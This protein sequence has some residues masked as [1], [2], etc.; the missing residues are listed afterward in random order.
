MP[1][2]AKF[3]KDILSNKRKLE[4]HETVCLNEECSVILLK[5]LPPILNDPGS[6]TISCTIG[7]NYFEHSL[8]DLGASV[9]LMPLSIYR[10]LGLGE[11]KPTTISL[12]LANRSIKRPK[13]IIEDEIVK[14]DKFIFPADFII[15]EME[16]DSNIPLI[17]GRPFLATGRALIDVYDRKMIF[18]VDNE[19]VIFNMFK[20]MKH[21]LTLDTCCQVDVL[22]VLVA[23]TFETEHQT[24]LCKAKIAQSGVI[25]AEKTEL[26]SLENAPILELKPLPSHPHYAYL[27]ESTTFPVIIA[28][29]MTMEEEIKL[30]ECML[31]QKRVESSGE[32]R[33]DTNT[34][35]D[36]MESMYRLQKAKQ[37]NQK[38]SFFIAIHWSDVGEVAG[39]SHYC[40]LGGYSRYNQ[41][42][43]APED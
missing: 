29:D 5:K 27:G 23:D 1:S 4:E 6:F 33:A 17:L 41:I 21:P 20:A 14:V 34:V 7:S 15:L 18:R 9:N 3:L 38:R 31:C 37:C 10:S 28:N 36:R 39:H 12:Q 43:I 8:C 26:P 42:V 32:Q 11:T 13:R 22:E 30:L 2:Y 16:E 35:S 25:S 24:V 19:Q 40:F